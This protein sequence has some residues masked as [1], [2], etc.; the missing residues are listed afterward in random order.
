MKVKR[1]TKKIFPLQ[2]SFTVEAGAL[3]GLVLLVIFFVL[4]LGAFVHGQAVLTVS[5]WEQAVTG[6]QQEVHEPFGL[7]GVSREVSFKEE[8]NRVA[9]RAGCQGVYGGFSKNIDVAVSYKKTK[10]A[11]FI[12]RMQAIKQR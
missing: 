11:A 5:A 2:G 10:P 9:Y 1:D 4:F 8:E 6:R 12:R 7:S 3:M